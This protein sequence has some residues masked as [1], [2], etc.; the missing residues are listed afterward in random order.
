MNPPAAQMKPARGCSLDAVWVAPRSKHRGYRQSGLWSL[1]G[2]GRG[3]S[4]TTTL[5]RQPTASAA[6]DRGTYVGRVTSRPWL[7]GA[8]VLGLAHAA[9]SLLWV[10]GSTWLLDTV[11]GTI[12]EWGR[13]GGSGVRLA[14]LVVVLAKVVAVALLWLAVHRGRRVEV[15]LAWTAGVV[16]TVYGGVLALV[17]AVYV[18]FS[19]LDDVADPYAVKWHAWFWDPWFLLWGICTLAALWLHRHGTVPVG[20]RQSD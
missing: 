11:G 16:L 3:P 15:A 4:A 2:R 20:P 12:E 7:L 19:S 5:G 17:G 14:L 9:V 13:D 8:T 1:G 6:V 10:C 18:S